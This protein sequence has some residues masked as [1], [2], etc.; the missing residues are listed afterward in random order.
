[1]VDQVA[2]T[3][4]KSFRL[5]DK[6]TVNTKRLIVSVSG[7]EKSGKTHFALTAPGP[8]AYFDTDVGTEGVIEK[9]VAAGK[10]IYHNG[11]DYH[12]LQDMRKKVVGPVDPEPYI[13][14]WE[15]MKSDYVQVMD[16]K[17]RTVV[18]DTGTEIW[19]LLRLA[20]FGKL[21]QVMPHHYGPVN[22]EYRQLL[23]LAYLSDKNLILLHKVKAEYVQEKRT[24]NWERAGFG[25]TGFMVQTNIRCWRRKND[26]GL[27]KFGITIEDCRQ[28]AEC[29]GLE[30]EEPLCDFSTVAAMITGMDVEAWR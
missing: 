4:P 26:D 6:G 18:M 12:E 8:I 11:Y 3:L 21:S 16:S 24:G 5:L 19:E 27:L 9:F 29:A 2:A 14:M 30:L 22:A 23:R 20:R 10:V 25:D 13:R 28:S 17:V 7:R 15:G 1:M